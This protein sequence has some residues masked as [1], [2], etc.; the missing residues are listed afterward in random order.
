MASDD[1]ILH[2]TSLQ[3]KFVDVAPQ[4]P[5]RGKTPTPPRPIRH[6]QGGTSR[7][8]LTRPFSIDSAEQNS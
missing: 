6:T 7:T 2:V 4:T 3:S 5:V 8:T 1:N